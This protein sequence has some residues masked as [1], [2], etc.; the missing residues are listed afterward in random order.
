MQNN[1]CNEE[2]SLLKQ[3]LKY[4]VKGNE[5][6]NETLTQYDI[7]NKALNNLLKDKDESIRQF[8]E[9]VKTLSQKLK[10]SEKT[11]FIE[12]EKN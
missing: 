11:H 8:E 2:I 10:T 6:L 7:K 4:E 1:Y 3:K 5:L 9:E 12:S